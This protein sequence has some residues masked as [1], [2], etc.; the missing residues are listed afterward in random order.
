MGCMNKM[1][2]CNI[3]HYKVDL[4]IAPY[5]F[6]RQRIRHIIGR[7]REQVRESIIKNGVEEED[8]GD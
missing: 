7:K 4:Y 5:L 6:T 3:F 2:S 1:Y 8:N